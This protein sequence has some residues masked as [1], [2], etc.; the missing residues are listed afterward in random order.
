MT[1]F[2]KFSSE[3]SFSINRY[4]G[5]QISRKHFNNFFQ[6][7]TKYVVPIKKQ[8]LEILKDF[9]VHETN[10][11]LLKTWLFYVDSKLLIQKT[12]M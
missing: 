12:R 5:I 9:Y 1:G 8:Y 4:F 2:E 10:M 7:N 11:R 6:N 3:H